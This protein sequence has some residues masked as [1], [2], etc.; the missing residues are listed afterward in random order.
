MAGGDVERVGSRFRRPDRDLPAL[1][2]AQ[3]AGKVVLDREAVDDGRSVRRDLD[4]AQH[5][6]PEAGAVLQAAA[7]FVGAPVL[8]RGVKLRDQVTVGGMDLDAVEARLLGA[9]GG[10]G[11]RGDGDLDARLGHFLRDDGLECGLVDRMGNGRGR[12]RRLAADVDAGM[13]AAMAEL[14]RRLRS[15]AMNL[16]DQ[17]RQP[18][19]EAIVVDSHLVAAV[20]AGL[21]RRRHLDGDEADAAA[22]PREIIGDAVVGDEAFR[23][24]RAR[25]HRRHDDPVGDL[26]RADARGRQQDV[27]DRTGRSSQHRNLAAVEIDGRPVHPGGA[28]GDDEGY[29]IGHVLDR[30]DSA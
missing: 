5:V 28:R 4:R 1:V 27:H 2:E 30:A 26:D 12:N 16:I 20:A 13:P 24:R 18:R 14:D 25:G 7:V 23:V 15:G 22:C 8:E 3:S 29:E 21:F 9:R 19:Q 11:V 10:G 6:E 17:P